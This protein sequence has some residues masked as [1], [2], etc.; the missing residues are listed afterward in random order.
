MVEKGRNCSSP[1]FNNIFNISLTSGVKLH[2]VKCGR[3][4][5]FFLISANL[6]CRGTDISKYFRAPLGLQDNE[7]RL[8]LE[9]Q[10]LSNKMWNK[11]ILNIGT[12]TIRSW[13]LYPYLTKQELVCLYAGN[14]ATHSND[15]QS[16]LVISKSKRRS[17]ILRDNRTSTY[18]I[19][20][21]EEKVNRT[22]TFH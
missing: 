13:R 12:F 11:N 20:R 19:C 8:P 7:S 14:F 1:L 9:R 6:I 17:E 4:I 3:S 22:T 2:I 16:T 18:Q 21:N 15:I 5:Y 10:N